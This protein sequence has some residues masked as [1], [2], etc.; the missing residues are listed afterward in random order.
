MKQNE[1]VVPSYSVPRWWNLKYIFTNKI[2][3]LSR[4]IL[5]ETYKTR[6]DLLTMLIN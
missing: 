3:F 4:D 1:F 2:S 5:E 6:Y